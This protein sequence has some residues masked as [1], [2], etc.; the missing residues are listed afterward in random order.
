MQQRIRFLEVRQAESTISSDEEHELKQLYAKLIPYTRRLA[1]IHQLIL[2]YSVRIKSDTE[3]FIVIEYF[4][5]HTPRSV[6]ASQDYY[7]RS[8]V[9]KIIKKYLKNA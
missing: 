1:E 5:N 8:G 7:D 6:I 4:V 3:R 2:D 9:Y